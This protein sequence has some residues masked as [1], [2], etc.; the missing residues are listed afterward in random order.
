VEDILKEF[1]KIPWIGPKSARAFWDVGVRSV[2]DLEKENPEKLFE[3]IRKQGG[4]T[5]NI[6]FLY[7]IRCAIYYLRE[8][9]YDPKLLKWWNWKGRRLEDK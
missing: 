4:P 5:I 1:Q 7:V 6:V 9:H 2:G 8:D 3:D